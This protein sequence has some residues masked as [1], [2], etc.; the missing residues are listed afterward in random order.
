[1]E[2]LSGVELI[3]VNI[4]IDEITLVKSADIIEKRTVRGKKASR[5]QK[6]KAASSRK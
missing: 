3:E 4:D 5:S 1:M 6:V 2:H